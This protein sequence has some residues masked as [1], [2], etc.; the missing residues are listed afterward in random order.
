MESPPS[1]W[2]TARVI[3]GVLDV[4]PQFCCFR[5]SEHRKLVFPGNTSAFRLLP[6]LPSWETP[7]CPR[8]YEE[9]PTPYI[10]M[11]ANIRSSPLL[12]ACISFRS[13][14]L[15]A[16]Y[17]TGRRLRALLDEL[18]SVGLSIVFRIHVDKTGELLVWFILANWRLFQHT[19]TIFEHSLQSS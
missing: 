2:S 14:W 18:P 15:Q 11:L 3:D 6:W 10:C 19:A 9:L 5:F 13:P 16:V 7:K 17:A 12:L 8:M 1:L 4:A